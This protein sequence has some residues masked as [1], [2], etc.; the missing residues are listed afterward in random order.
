MSST[1]ESG[2]TRPEH[3]PADGIDIVRNGDDPDEAVDVQEVVSPGAVEATEGEITGGYA[4][5]GCTETSSPGA[6]GD[7]TDKENLEDA[8]TGPSSAPGYG[9]INQDT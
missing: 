4:A 7:P 8:V 1:F 6:D 5:S 3:R 9:L 2:K